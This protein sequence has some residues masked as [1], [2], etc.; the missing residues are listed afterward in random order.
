[1]EALAE[2]IKG[3]LQKYPQETI[4]GQFTCEHPEG[5]LLLGNHHLWFHSRGSDASKRVR[6][7]IL[8]HHR[9]SVTATLFFDLHLI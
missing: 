4:I 3:I 2:E 8:T 7:I 9:I 1:M 6:L 5:I